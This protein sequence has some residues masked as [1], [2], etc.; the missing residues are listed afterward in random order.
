MKTPRS[1]INILCMGVQLNAHAQ[2]P[3]AA[4]GAAKGGHASLRKKSARAL[5]STRE[6]A[7]APQPLTPHATCTGFTILELLVTTA[8]L[9]IITGLLLSIFGKSSDAWISAQQDIERHRSARIGLELMNRELLQALM[10]TSAIKYRGSGDITTSAAV[11][12]FGFPTSVFFIASGSTDEAD[13]GGDLYEIGYTLN[14]NSGKL[15]RYSTPPTNDT[16]I[17]PSP[18]WNVRATEPANIPEPWEWPA[19]LDTFL[20][21]PSSEPDS[22]VAEGVVDLRFYYSGPSLVGVTNSWATTN[23]GDVYFTGPGSTPLLPAS[24]PT[25]VDIHIT[26]MPVTKWKQ[27]RQL[28]LSGSPNAPS[29]TN[30]Y[31]RTFQTTV[32]INNREYQ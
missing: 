18:I 9:V 16:T 11:N 13:P 29:I 32:H 14:V 28:V 26:T 5:I 24:L 2:M 8:L 30:Q 4:C 20:Y 15:Y 25:T 1:I 3:L 12:F 17:L 6:G 19:L 27:W 31:S 10:S 21:N 22:L 23:V 7:C